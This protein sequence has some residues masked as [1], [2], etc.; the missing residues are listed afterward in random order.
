MGCPTLTRLASSKKF[1]R[2]FLSA[3]AG[4]G[5]SPRESR[6]E[7]TRQEPAPEGVPKMAGFFL[8]ERKPVRFFY[9]PPEN[10]VEGRCPIAGIFPAGEEGATGELPKTTR[11]KT[12]PSA[13][14]GSPESPA[15]R[16]CPQRPSPF[17]VVMISASSDAEIIPPPTTTPPPSL[18]ITS[19]PLPAPWRQRARPFPEVR[20]RFRCRR[21][22]PGRGPR[23]CRSPGRW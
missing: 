5:D 1:A 18:C 16:V 6:S 23:S 8:P 7:S 4:G 21:P 17:G 20:G 3:W 2:S 15:G 11:G 13:T 19:G 9:T 10:G 14:S 12:P 22:A